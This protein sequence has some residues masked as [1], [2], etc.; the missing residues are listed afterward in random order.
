MQLT[1]E[2][3]SLMS[4]MLLE[5][6]GVILNDSKKYLIESRLGP[7]IGEFGCDNWNGLYMKLRHSECNMLTEAVIDAIT[8]H[9]TLFFRDNSP[10]EALQHKALPEMIDAKQKTATPKKLRIWSA[11]SSTGQEPYSIAMVLSELIPDID[12]WDIKILGTDISSGS[13]AQAS[14]G[15]YD[16]NDLRRGMKP[17]FLK[18]YFLETDD[19][20][21]V[22][23][24]IR[25]L[26]TFQKRNL[27]DSFMGLE[28]FDVVFCRNVSI[29]FD[30]GTQADLYKRMKAQL[31]EESYLFTGS[32]EIL[33][34]FGPE[35]Q[36]QYHCGSVFYR[37][38][39]PVAV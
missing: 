34:S 27:L 20:W 3:F 11:A 36:P 35:F 18:K 26:V 13:I 25:S 15:V 6:C 31:W 22:R 19:G 14:L 38:L 24:K 4:K 9:E 30:K 28:I 7:I 21:R 2:D 17:E 5:L 1:D 37:P 32:T 39:K 12:T 16:E 8:T 33:T 23:D 10:F 29:Y